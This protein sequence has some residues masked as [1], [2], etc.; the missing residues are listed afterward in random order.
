MALKI[1]LLSIHYSLFSRVA[2]LDLIEPLVFFFDGLGPD[3]FF[4]GHEAGGV[5]VGPA[6]F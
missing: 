2:L 4:S 3:A 1:S 5:V 6:S